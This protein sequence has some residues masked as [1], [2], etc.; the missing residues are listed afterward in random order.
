[1]AEETY[2]G[3][4]WRDVIAALSSLVDLDATARTSRALLR[5]REIRSGE[6]LLRLVVAWGSGDCHPRQSKSHASDFNGQGNGS[7]MIRL[8]SPSLPPGM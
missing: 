7:D 6:A 5:R 2:R 8:P 3:D 4:G 1:M